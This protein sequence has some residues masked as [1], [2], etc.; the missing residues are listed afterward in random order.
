LNGHNHFSPE[1]LELIGLALV[2]KSRSAGDQ[3]RVNEIIERIRAAVDEQATALQGSHDETIR[4]ELLARFL[5]SEDGQALLDE[6]QRITA[7][8]PRAVVKVEK[9]TPEAAALVG[10]RIRKDVLTEERVVKARDDRTSLRDACNDESEA[11]Y[12]TKK[13]ADLLADDARLH[14]E[15]LQ[16]P[17]GVA[18]IEQRWPGW[19]DEMVDLATGA[20]FGDVGD[21]D[22][23]AELCRQ[24]EDVRKANPEMSVE[25]ART[26]AM[27]IFPDLTRRV[28]QTRSDD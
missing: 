18:E 19:L 26:R 3:R 1:T 2:A 11:E 5:T 12:R 10:A 28:M 25:Q 20:P 24:A 23:W 21:A 17:K 14:A 22:A 15:V 27:E 13:V 9:G 8:A 6:L 16:T 4:D 7:P